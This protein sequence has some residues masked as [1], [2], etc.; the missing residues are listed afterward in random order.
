MKIEDCFYIGY[1]T[2][3]KGLKGEV[4][5]FFEYDEPADLNFKT[6]FIEISGKLVPFFTSTYKTHTNQTGNFYFDDLD[7]IEKAQAIVRK[8]VY[9]PNS[10]KPERDPDDF[11]WFDLKGYIVHDKNHGELGEIIEVHEY[12]QQY[13]ATVPYRF[14]E[15]MFPLNDEIIQSID[16]EQKILYIRLPDGLLEVYLNQ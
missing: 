12:P 8:K 15:V 4:Q 13:I 3:T 11:T 5:L 1:I 6:V 7:T 2:K 9:L 14:R 16:E 10:E